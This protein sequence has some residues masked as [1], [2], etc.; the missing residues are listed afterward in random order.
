MART[1]K[2]W[3]W[4]ERKA[5]FVTVRGRRHNLGPDKAEAAR[6]FHELMAER[7]APSPAAPAVPA[8]LSVAELFDNF[9]DRTRRHREAS[10]FE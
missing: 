6:R 7:P 3:Y 2:P 1:P 9:L 10:T 8:E 4:D 5:Y